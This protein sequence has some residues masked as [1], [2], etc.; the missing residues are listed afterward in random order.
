MQTILSDFKDRLIE[1]YGSLS[2]EFTE[3][4]KMMEYRHIRTFEQIS[5][6]ETEQE[7]LNEE[8]S[9]LKVG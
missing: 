1:K 8:F 3:Q 9:Q 6:L 4:F 2:D 5:K 7:L